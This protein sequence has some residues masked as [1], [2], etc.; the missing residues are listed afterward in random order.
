MRTGTN[1]LDNQ[2][3][4]AGVYGGIGAGLLGASWAGW[5]PKYMYENRDFFNPD[6]F[7]TNFPGI[8]YN[9][10]LAGPQPQLHLHNTN[11]ILGSPDCKQFSNLGTKRKDRG[12]LADLPITDFDYY[13][14]LQVINMSLPDTFILENVPNVS[15]TIWIKNGQLF[16]KGYSE[17]EPILLLNGYKTQSIILD[18][19][20]YGVA[21]HRKRLYVIGAR[22]F[23][24]AYDPAGRTRGLFINKYARDRQMEV[25]KV[26]LDVWDAL[27]DLAS[28]N[29]AAI[30]VA[31]HVKP[32]HSAKRIEGFKA[33]APGDSY[34]NTQNNRRLLWYTPS[35][36]VAS[37]CS[38]FVHPSEPRVLTVRESA[39]LMGFPDGF[40]FKGSETNQLDQVGKSLVPHVIMCLSAYLRQELD[41]VKAAHT[42]HDHTEDED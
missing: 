15:K 7:K 42:T 14:F 3:T 38:R 41:K 10:T 36:V 11:L 40:I 9:K 21:Q 13:K 30:T 5:K 2:Y 26:H 31:N 17:D 28:D 22:K 19:Y 8:P 1:Y 35:G 27:W 24:P 6:T 4:V 18:A 25:N 34:Y 20:D 33:L 32:H 16:F 23:Q 37:H 12:K 29:P 39:R